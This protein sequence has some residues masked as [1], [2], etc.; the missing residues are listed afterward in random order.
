M[1]K[2]IAPPVSYQGAYNSG[3][4]IR[5]GSMDNGNSLLIHARQKVAKIELIF[6]SDATCDLTIRSTATDNF[7]YGTWFGKLVSPYAPPPIDALVNI[8]QEYYI[9]S[10]CFEFVPRVGTSRDL[11]ITW[12]W[13]QDVEYP[14]AHSAF[15]YVSSGGSGGFKVSEDALSALPSAKQFPAWAPEMCMDVS[16]MIEKKWR[17]T[18]GPDQGSNPFNPT[19]IAADQRMTYYGVL[20]MAGD[21]NSGTASTSLFIGS[22]YVEYKVRLRGLGQTI[23]SEIT[24]TRT[25]YESERLRKLLSVTEEKTEKF[26]PSSIPQSK[27]E[28]VASRSESKERVFP[29]T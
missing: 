16:N 11:A 26:I 6:G 15:T 13:M 20:G 29:K 1:S 14:E 23:D 5:Y 19:D 7:F 18:A 2:R 10:C 25:K 22:L 27:R 28:K 3:M 9:D 8:H 4:F 17:Y 21:Q 24:S 12:A